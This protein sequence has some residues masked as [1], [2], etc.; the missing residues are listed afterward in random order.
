MGFVREERS[1]NATEDDERVRGTPSWRDDTNA[2]RDVARID[3]V[4]SH[5]RPEE[6]VGGRDAPQHVEWTP[7]D[8]AV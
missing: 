6:C 5:R 1:V 3:Q 8:Q 2:E 4:N 7:S